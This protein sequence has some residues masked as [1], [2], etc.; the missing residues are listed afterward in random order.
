MESLGVYGAVDCG[1]YVSDFILAAKSFGVGSTAQ[2]MYSAE[3]R[4]HLGLPNHFHSAGPT[5]SVRPTN[6][7]LTAQTLPVSG[8]ME[9]MVVPRSKAYSFTAE[10]CINVT[11]G[12]AVRFI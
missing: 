3:I 12:G 7:A 10:Q 9:I 5:G 2:A 8:N 4:A 1:G 6:I 11:L